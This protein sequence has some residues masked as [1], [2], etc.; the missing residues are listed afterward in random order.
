MLDRR[1]NRTTA[2][3]INEALKIQRDIGFEPAL[4]FLR[5]KGVSVDL[6]RDVLS[7]YRD[8]RV[9]ERRNLVLRQVS[10]AELDT[11]LEARQ[12]KNSAVV[13]TKLL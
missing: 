4:L 1:Q 10:P 2:V 11:E 7:V 9:R 5:A 12:A 13:G 8:R 6:A 3:Q